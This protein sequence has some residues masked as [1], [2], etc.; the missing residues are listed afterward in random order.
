MDQRRRCISDD[1]PLLTLGHFQG[2]FGQFPVVLK[3]MSPGQA[4]W[5]RITVPKLLLSSSETT[6]QRQF[7]EFRDDLPCDPVPRA[8]LV[9][10]CPYVPVRLSL[11]VHNVLPMNTNAPG[12]HLLWTH[13]NGDKIAIETLSVLLDNVDHKYPPESWCHS[14]EHPEFREIAPRKPRRQR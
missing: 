10:Q 8:A 9:V 1:R 13:Q 14:R 7:R 3:A 4:F 12:A 2:F 6:L 5:T 11:V